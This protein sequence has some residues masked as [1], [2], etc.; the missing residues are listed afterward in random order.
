LN[1]QQIQAPEVVMDVIVLMA[2][3]LFVGVFLISARAHLMQTGMLAGYAGS[4]GVPL[5][6]PVVLISG[7]QIQ[8]GGLSVLLG[9]RADLGAVLLVAFLVPTAVVM[10][11]FWR[12][13]EPQARM[14]EQTQFV[15]DLGL[16]GGVLFLRADRTPS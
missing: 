15:K 5:A 12:E 14:V 13:S 9:V 11:D 6:R 8:L 1:R 7:M 2:R 4:K 10:H 3:I 16:A